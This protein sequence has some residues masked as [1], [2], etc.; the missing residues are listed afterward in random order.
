MIA[1]EKIVD[2]SEMIWQGGGTITTSGSS[3]P[4][5]SGFFVPS[6]GSKLPLRRVDRAEYNTRKGNKPSRLVAIVETRR[7]SNAAKLLNDKEAQP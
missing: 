6:T 7:L 3:A 2:I 1:D 5:S 4:V